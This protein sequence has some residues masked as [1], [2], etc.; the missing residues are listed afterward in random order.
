[1][2]DGCK[3]KCAKLQHFPPFDAWKWR[4]ESGAVICEDHYS[5]RTVFGG[6]GG[7]GGLLTL[8]IVTK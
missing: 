3:K 5:Q 2:V 8:V 6:V 4:S 7:V 1:M